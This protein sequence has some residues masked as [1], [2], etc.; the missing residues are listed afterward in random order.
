MKF[1]STFDDG[2][3]GFGQ[4]MAA[5]LA[6]R[7]ESF[8][9]LRHPIL[10]G[11]GDGSVLESYDAGV[12]SSSETYPTVTGGRAGQYLKCFFLTRK[13]IKR[14]GADI[15]VFVAHS[16]INA[17][18]AWTARGNT[19]FK[20]VYSSIDYSPHRFT[21]AALNMIFSVADRIAYRVVDAMWH[22]YPEAERLKPYAKNARCFET[23][24]GN[25]FRRVERL[26]WEERD[27]F[28][29]VFFG[30]VTPRANIEAVLGCLRELSAE[31][32]AVFMDV[33]GTSRHDPSYM[34]EVKAMADSLGVSGHVEWHG[35]IEQPSDC[36]KILVRA[37]LGLC[38]YEMDESQVTWYVVPGKVFAY[39]ACGL[40]VLV[41]DEIGPVCTREVTEN[42]MGL[43][44]SL[45][46]MAATIA[47]L[48]RRPDFHESLVE[49]AERWGS[50]FDWDDKFDKY[51]AL[52]DE[53]S[54]SE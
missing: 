6:R 51:F 1:V 7:K 42:G 52:L 4:E 22:T 2:A 32:P 10:P 49:S 25:N 47:D 9:F 8:L 48:F 19:A 44:T 36:E 20:I 40:P 50:K 26:P 3:T 46:K 28:R 18:A 38:M 34:D 54:G 43:V 41:S 16:N 30:G 5:H 15:D 27:R 24:H 53:S 13:L 14:H 35:L 31:F 33:I 29:L 17:I 12:L 37:G 21:N 45:D 39:A 11:V 23:F